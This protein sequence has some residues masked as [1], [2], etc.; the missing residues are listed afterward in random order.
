MFL[1]FTVDESLHLFHDGLVGHKVLAVALTIV[2]RGKKS[3]E[4][5]HLAVKEDVAIAADAAHRSRTET[6]LLGNI[7]LTKGRQGLT[8]KKIAF[9]TIQ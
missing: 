2:S 6:R 1:I 7:L 3:L 8:V 9:L 5:I 4:A